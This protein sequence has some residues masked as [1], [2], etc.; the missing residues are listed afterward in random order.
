RGIPAAEVRTLGEALDATWLEEVAPGVSLTPSEEVV[1]RVKQ[2]VAEHF[3]V[4]GRWLERPTK[5]RQ[6]AFPR[7]VA[8]YL[9]YRACALPLGR[10]GEAAEVAAMVH[11]ALEGRWED[12]RRGHFDLYNLFQGM[13]IETNP[14]PVKT[15]LALMGRITE[16][17]RL[18]IC[19]MSEANRE[20][21]ESLLRG[22]ALLP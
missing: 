4:E 11:A 14:I 1:R 8:M 10:L 21:L 16:E 19:S 15:A 13:F 3:G 2:V 20:K 9:V 17:F 18:P 7:R 5:L 22:Y 6:A 12:A